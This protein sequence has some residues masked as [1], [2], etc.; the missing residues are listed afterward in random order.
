MD[1]QEKA[2]KAAIVPPMAKKRL[3]RGRGRNA[4]KKKVTNK[5]PS[6]PDAEGYEV[7]NSWTGSNTLLTV[8]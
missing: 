2:E 8:I 7:Y 5:F 1:E 3:K 6:D 4:K